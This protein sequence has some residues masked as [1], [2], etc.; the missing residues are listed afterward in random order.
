LPQPDDDNNNIM[1]IDDEALQMLQHDAV[2]Q[3]PLE[4][5]FNQRSSDFG[6]NLESPI[7]QRH[8]VMEEKE[9]CCKKKHCITWYTRCTNTDL[10]YH[11][12]H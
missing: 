11:T 5:E 4:L 9:V 6:L 2:Q 10:A 8:I 1:K 12:N 7:E 3:N